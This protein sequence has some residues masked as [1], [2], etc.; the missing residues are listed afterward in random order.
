[1]AESISFSIIVEKRCKMTDLL[2][3]GNDAVAQRQGIP[4]KFEVPVK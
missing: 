2:A 1:M 3:K 4:L